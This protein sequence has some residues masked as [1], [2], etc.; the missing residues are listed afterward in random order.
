MIDQLSY[1]IMHSV[2]NALLV[3]IPDLPVVLWMEMMLSQYLLDEYQFVDFCKRG[4]DTHP[5]PFATFLPI[6]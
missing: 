4:S 3:V 5:R 6:A 1:R 2:Q